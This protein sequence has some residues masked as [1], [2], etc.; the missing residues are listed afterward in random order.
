MR[1]ILSLLILT[2]VV[3]AQ[4]SPAAAMAGYRETFQKEFLSE[5]W[6]GDREESDACIECH[7]SDI[8]KPEFRNIITE[9]KKSWHY[10]NDVSCHNCHGGDPK[11][12]STSM[13]PH[14]AFA[15]TPKSA[16]VPEFCGKCHIGILKNYLE[17]GHGKSLKSSGKGPTCVACHGSHN[18]QKANIDIINEKLC[19]ECHSY[20]RSKVMRQALFL[21][22]KKIE[23]LNNRLDQL[24]TEGIVADEEAKSLFSTYGEFRTLFHTEDVSL[25]K[26]RTD[27]FTKKLGVI[28]KRI[29][30]LFDELRF[31]RN[32]SA[33]LALVFMGIGAV[34][35]LIAKTKKP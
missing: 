18:I 11:D 21:T 9:W 27:E 12:A 23:E 25:V 16:R 19:T 5:P 26:Q 24:K 30:Y 17:S 3:A 20:E 1:Y 4:A 2:V 15:G 33:F 32:F 8:I 7:S 22:E 35:L 14:R 13:D 31:R 34:I 10:Q 6:A 29:Q 28:D